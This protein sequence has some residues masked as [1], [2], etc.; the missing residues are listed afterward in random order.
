MG[1]KPIVTLRVYRGRV[2]S[3]DEHGNVQ[4][5]NQTVKLAHNT[6]E[7]KNFMTNLRANG[8]C[9]V[10][11]EKV[12]NVKVTNKADEGFKS[13][14]TVIDKSEISEEVKIAYAIPKQALTPQEQKIKDLEDKLEALL[15]AQSGKAESK[16][17]KAVEQSTDDKTEKQLLTEKYIEKFGKKPFAAWDEVKLA[18]KLAE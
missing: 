9:K 11:V 18:E 13:T 17:V 7:W 2:L 14:Q 5:E 6:V 10:E 8:Y 3:Y 15:K 16:T 12:T 1:E 4:N